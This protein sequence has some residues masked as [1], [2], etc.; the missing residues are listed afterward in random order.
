M[1]ISA[2]RYTELQVT[3]YFSF[4]RGASSPIELFDAEISQKGCTSG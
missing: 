4:L 3:T 1:T 2:P